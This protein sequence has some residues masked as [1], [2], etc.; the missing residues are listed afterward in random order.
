MFAKN[1]F[2]TKRK[3]MSSSIPSEILSRNEVNRAEKK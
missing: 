3:R 2:F 1:F